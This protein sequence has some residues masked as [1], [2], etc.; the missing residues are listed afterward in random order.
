MQ[1][2]GLSTIERNVTMPD[3][4]FIEDLPPET[5]SFAL[6]MTTNDQRDTAGCHDAAGRIFI[7][8]FDL[9]SRLVICEDIGDRLR[10]VAGPLPG[11]K[12]SCATLMITEDG[13]IRVYYGARAADE[14][15]GPFPLMREKIRV[16]GVR[17]LRSL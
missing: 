4:L 5:E 10:Y 11:S 15:G 7:A 12:S 2:S 8:W 16:P 3:E 13:Y 6:R 14:T 9:Q 17:A 1:P